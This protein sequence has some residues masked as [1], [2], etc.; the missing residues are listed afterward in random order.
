MSKR[1][2]AAFAHAYAFAY[3]WPYCTEIFLPKEA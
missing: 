2:A 1:T 3:A